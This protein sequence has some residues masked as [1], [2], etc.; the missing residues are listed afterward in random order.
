M[1]AEVVS[2]FCDV[3]NTRTTDSSRALVTFMVSTEQVGYAAMTAGWDDVFMINN[4]CFAFVGLLM[5]W[6]LILTAIKGTGSLKCHF[7]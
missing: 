1:L 2:D 4:L 6:Q 5:S 3:P 7:D